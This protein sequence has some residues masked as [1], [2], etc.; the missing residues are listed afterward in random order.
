MAFA[1]PV[2]AFHMDVQGNFK[3]LT[4]QEWESRF[5]DYEFPSRPDWIASYLAGKEG[6]ALPEARELKGSVYTGTSNIAEPVNS[7]DY[8]I[9]FPNPARQEAFLRFVLNR[10]EDL[11]LEVNDSSGRLLHAE[12]HPQLPAAEHHISLPIQ[13]WGKGIFLV[14]TLVG[15]QAGIRELVIR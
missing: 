1:G 4:D 11:H 12:V 9:L 7:M 3:R 15:D 13:E 8:M 14:R 5:W 2:S 10:S 6:E